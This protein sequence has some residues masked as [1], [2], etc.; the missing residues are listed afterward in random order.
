MAE[1]SL[2]NVSKAFGKTQAV[3]APGAREPGPASAAFAQDERIMAASHAS[4]RVTTQHGTSGV[5]CEPFACIPNQNLV[6][7]AEVVEYEIGGLPGAPAALLAG[8]PAEAGCLPVPALDGALAIAP[9]VAILAISVLPDLATK[10]WCGQATTT[11]HYET[12]LLEPGL[13]VT[14]QVLSLNNYLRQTGPIPSLSRP[15]ELRTQ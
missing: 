11:L 8:L 4:L 14:F 10:H 5:A 7:S 2:Q 13:V 6:G 9:P 3:A 15:T 12:P 1:V